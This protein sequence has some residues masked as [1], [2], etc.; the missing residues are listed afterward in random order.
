VFFTF[1]KTIFSVLFYRFEKSLAPPRS[2]FQ[3]S[4]AACGGGLA[5]F[6]LGLGF[7]RDQASFLFVLFFVRTPDLPECPKTGGLITRLF[8]LFAF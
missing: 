1:S 8:F 6:Q 4:P 5:E 2:R 7:S 3:T